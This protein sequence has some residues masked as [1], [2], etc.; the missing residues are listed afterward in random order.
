MQ[1]L[2]EIFNRVQENKKKLK[3]LRD[4]YKEA[5][6]GD[7]SYLDTDEALKTAREKKKT[8]ELSIK[9][10]FAS[11]FVKMDDLKIDIASDQEMINDIA[12]TMIMKGE[13]VSVND[14]YDNEYEPLFTVKFKK[15]T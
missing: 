15:V 5:L 2:Q 9:E 13:T 4:A 7:Q 12:M 8:L 11:E 6:T 3:D 14:K 10:Q 1:D